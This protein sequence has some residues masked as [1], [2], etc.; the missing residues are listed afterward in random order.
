MQ[1]C[2]YCNTEFKISFLKF[3]KMKRIT[4]FATLLICLVAFSCNNQSLDL[5]DILGRM[6]PSVTSIV[7]LKNRMINY[8]PVEYAGIVEQIFENYGY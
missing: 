4:L 6:V 7:A 2:V 5:V 1:K 8:G 3:I